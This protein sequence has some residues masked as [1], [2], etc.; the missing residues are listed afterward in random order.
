M[1]N[2]FWKINSASPF[3]TLN[4]S[5]TITGKWIL[6]VHG[7]NRVD[8]ETIFFGAKD[9]GTCGVARWVWALL[10]IE[11][12]LLRP[13]PHSPLQIQTPH[14]LRGTVVW[15]V[16]PPFCPGQHALLGLCFLDTQH[17]M[18]SL[19]WVSSSLGFS[20]VSAFFLEVSLF[21]S[22]LWTQWM[23]VLNH[24]C[25]C[26]GKYDKRRKERDLRSERRLHI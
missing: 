24:Y 26:L 23:G 14:L 1:F 18:A 13:P 21:E 20:L 19:L 11:T 9:C 16:T 6:E 5:S 3:V 15:A 12:H 22:V 8:D 17:G 2:S 4:P 10:T 7:D 25:H